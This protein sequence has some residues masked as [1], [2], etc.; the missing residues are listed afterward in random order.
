VVR[1][2]ENDVRTTTAPRSSPFRSFSPA[3][4]RPSRCQQD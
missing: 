3:S 1:R 2:V 4:K